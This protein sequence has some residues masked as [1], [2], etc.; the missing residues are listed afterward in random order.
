[1]ITLPVMLIIRRANICP[2]FFMA[3]TC[4]FFRRRFRYINYI[5]SCLQAQWFRKRPW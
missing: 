5:R 1:L 3:I 4:A 2:A